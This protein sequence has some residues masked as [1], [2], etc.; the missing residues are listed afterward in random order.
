M[1]DFEQVDRLF[2]QYL[3]KV[4]QL[5]QLLIHY[6]PPT[7][8]DINIKSF[9]TRF[10]WIFFLCA[11]ESIWNLKFSDVFSGYIKGALADDRLKRMKY[12]TLIRHSSQWVF[13]DATHFNSKNSFA[14]S[15]K[16]LMALQTGVQTPDSR[17][18]WQAVLI[19]EPIALST[20]R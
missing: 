16:L 4:Q 13:S 14:T 6:T 11:S 2:D 5:G 12:L 15:Q 17:C 1:V 8:T 10:K 3:R 20:I 7:T 9:S 18:S 19:S